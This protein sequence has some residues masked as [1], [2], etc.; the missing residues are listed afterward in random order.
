MKN[1]L[2]ISTAIL[3][4]STFASCGH[5][6][7]VVRENPLLAQ[8]DTP[9]GV[10]PFDKIEASDYQ[11]AIEYAIKKHDDE[12]TA[13]VDNPSAPTFENTILAYDN[14]GVL[15]ERITMVFNNVV[16]ADATEELLDAKERIAPMLA[17]HDD[18]VMLNA[19]LFERIAHVY[20]SQ[21][22]TPPISEQE[23]LQQRLT[24]RIYDK[25]VRSGAGLDDESKKEFAAINLRLSELEF[26]FNKNLL[27][28]NGRF[29]LV[30]AEDEL[31]GLPT[32]VRA[33]AR[34][35]A[36]ERGYGEEKYLFDTSKSSMISFLTY[37]SRRDLRQRLY[38]AYLEKC[39]G[40]DE[41]DNNDICNEI[42]SL[43]TRRAQ[44]LGYPTYAAYILA[45]NMAATPENVYEL[46]DS[47]WS[48][49]LAKA[50]EELEE[51]RAEKLKEDGSDDFRSWDWWYYSE[52]IR[53]SRYD[54]DQDALRP[55]FPLENV[56]Q[57][58]FELSNRLY[59]VTFQP[60]VLPVYN[61]ECST[62]EVYDKDGKLLGVLYLDLHS[63]A[64]RKGPGAWCDTM[65]RSGYSED[66]VKTVPVVIISANFARPVS[67]TIPALL[68]L[69]ET[70][71]FFHEFGHALHFLFTDSPYR[72]LQGV[73]N[74]FVEL[75]SQIMENWATHPDMLRSYAIH[76]QNGKVIPDNLINKIQSAA[77]HNK[78][79][80]TVELLAASYSDMDIHNIANYTPRPLRAYE[81]QILNEQR[82]MIDQIEP[83]Y[84]YPYFAHIMEG[85]YAAGYYGYL[86]S[87]VLDKDAFEAFVE[88]GDVFDKRVAARFRDEIL[89]R[90]GTEDGMTLY[91]NF[92]GRKPIRT[93]LLKSRGLYDD[94]AEIHDL[95]EDN[96]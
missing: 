61:E 75:P 94:K 54:I 65:I 85:E 19:Q 3:T 96:K 74:D 14:S 80:E 18:A 37:S 8:W 6:E 72:G 90:G 22:N 10:P 60:V 35:A 5:E 44:L 47:V 84:R 68:D 77:K 87:E 69:D 43:R 73:E 93:A 34:T 29:E 67:S 4:M 49:A 15:L 30:L 79:F 39:N 82:G 17:E 23:R 81:R 78:G 51:L 53:K 7:Q 76:W 52:K 58:V 2:L 40:G 38:E 50:K 16:L 46:L 56:K 70:G 57:G 83:R 63:R 42:I 41:Y 55:F 13:I 59:G 95:T 21:K 25:F 1:F 45:D 66:G 27:A 36:K 64:G 28:E 26:Q 32:T 11:P 20:E 9:H 31:D 12:I 33:A 71:T 62:Y 48:P 91:I 24:K 88:S 89:S 92:R 86:W